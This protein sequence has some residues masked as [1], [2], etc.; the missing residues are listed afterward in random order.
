MSREKISSVLFVLWELAKIVVLMITS[1]YL[2]FNSRL[3]LVIVAPY[4]VFKILKI[5]GLCHERMKKKFF[6]QFKDALGCLRTA[7][8]AGYSMEKA[9]S[10]ARN[11]ME[12]M[13]GADACMTRELFQMEKKL[14][15]GQTIEGVVEEFAMKTDVREII[16]FS[17][18]LTAAKRSGGNIINLIREAGRNLYEKIELQREIDSIISANRTECMVMQIM[19]LGIL[20]YFRV[21]SPSFLQPL[22]E[23]FAGRL[24]MLIVAAIYFVM[25]EYS[26]RIV[27][28]VGGV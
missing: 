4:G 26:Q 10:S 27:D 12:I 28:K 5:K 11:D 6:F 15:L 22:Y 18:T 14:Q 25:S 9:V 3:G 1:A 7:L 23:T 17:D 2:F 13:F 20:F 8:E 24:C 16:S 21:F 19:P